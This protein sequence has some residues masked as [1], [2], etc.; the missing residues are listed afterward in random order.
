MK[1]K[2]I[3]KIQNTIY[4]AS[5]FIA[6]NGDGDETDVTNNLL[7]ALSECRKLLQN[8]MERICLNNAKKK[9]K[10]TKGKWQ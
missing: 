7:T 5:D 2:D 3:T 9:L 8:E 6:T 1:V 10:I 4:D